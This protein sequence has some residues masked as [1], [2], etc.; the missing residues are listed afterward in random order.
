MSK[1]IHDEGSFEGKMGQKIFFQFFKPKKYGNVVIYVHGVGEHSGRY[2]FPI[3]YFI[4]KGIAFYGLDHRGHGRSEGKRGHV[5]HFSDYIDDL[6]MFVNLV[7]KREGEK[8]YFLFGHSLGGLI[9]IR[10]VEESPEGAL[11]P[12]IDGV[13]VSSPTLKFKMEIPKLKAF[14]GDKFSRYLPKFSMTNE[15][16]PIFLTHDKTVVKKYMKD[17]LVHNKISARLFTEM[18]KAM[19]ESMEKASE[20]ELPFLIMHAGDDELVSPDGSR[21]F[22]ERLGSKDKKLIIYKEFYHELINE[23]ERKKV[24]KDME[25]WLKPRLGG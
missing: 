2:L 1:Y 4:D 7:Q 9:T 18:V 5:N 10:F 3:E 19:N 11:T 13:M 21:E 20:V 23:V 6:K 12:R 24:F 25:K 8:K 14:M 17:D 16:D 15:I 22:H